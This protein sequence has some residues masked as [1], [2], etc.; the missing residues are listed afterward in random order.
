TGDSCAVGVCVGGAPANCDD[1]N[2]CTDDSCDPTAGCV[3]LA[4]AAPCDDGDLCT[5]IDV[6]A[7]G[8]CVGGAPLVC[9]DGEVCT[10]DSCDA[11]LGCLNANNTAACDD[12]DACT[13]GDSCAVGVCVGGA[14]ANCDDGNVCTDDSCDPAAGC[15]SASN[16][17]ACNDGDACTTVDACVGGLCVGGVA[18]NCDD[19]NVCTDDSCVP[20]AGCTSVGNTASCDDGDACTAGDTCAAGVCVGGAAPV[21]DDGNPCTDDSCDS[22]TGCVGI[23]NSA[24]CDDGDLCTTV[25]LCSAGVCTGSIPLQCDDGFWCNGIETCDA[26]LGCAPGA[27]VDCSDGVVCT[28]DVCNE[29]DDVCVHMP[30]NL[31][32]DDGVFCNGGETC[33]PVLD[34]QAAAPADCSVLN[35]ACTLGVCDVAVD[36]CVAVGINEAGP[37]DDQDICSTDDQCVVGMCV[38][39]SLAHLETKVTARVRAG[40][41]NDKLKVIAVMG[42]NDVSGYDCSQALEI[43][44]LNGD[45]EAIYSGRVPAS[46]FQ[47]RRGDGVVCRFKDKFGL[48]A[49]AHGLTRAILRRKVRTGTMIVKAKMVGTELTNVP[50]AGQ[51]EVMLS[52]LFGDAAT[53]PCLTARALSCKSSSRSL[54]CFLPPTAP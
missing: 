29:L 44:V 18:P 53:G 13:T 32:C 37:C 8:S 12:G 30:S 3:N 48:I 27:A 20:A 14:P 23:A 28:V 24:S 39:T 38:G 41:A 19:G 49:D 10:D 25:D 15:T 34:C 1:G 16:T 43:V 50:A 51:A 5:T 35:G 17:A 54:R 9:D 21:C 52:T 6:C 33:D 36:G 47:D 4:N 7:A 42:L 22:L 31:V 40:G 2:V 26:V 46:L 11:V 45:G